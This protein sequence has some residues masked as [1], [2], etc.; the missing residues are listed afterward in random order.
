LTVLRKKLPA[1][2]LIKTDGNEIYRAMGIHIGGGFLLTA[3]HVIPSIA[4]LQ[5][6]TFF[7]LQSDGT[8]D[9]G[10]AGNT[11]T[12]GWFFQPKEGTAHGESTCTIDA[13]VIRLPRPPDHSITPHLGPSAPSGNDWRFLCLHFGLS[14]TEQHPQLCVAAVSDFQQ[15]DG[16]WAQLCKADVGPGGSGS[17]VLAIH[18]AETV[19]SVGMVLG[20]ATAS[21]ADNELIILS[22]NGM[23]VALQ[24]V[25]SYLGE[26][27]CSLQPG[28]Q[29]VPLSEAGESL[30]PFR[31]SQVFP[32]IR[33][34]E[35]AD[36]KALLEV[37]L[38]CFRTKY[39]QEEALPA[40]QR[41]SLF[42]GDNLFAD[43][44]QARQVCLHL[45]TVC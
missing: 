28:V 38:A 9:R 32:P 40:Y 27:S 25:Q 31:N 37:M 18:E 20:K 8:L 7:F 34:A 39:D 43:D 16:P 19:T 1:I 23:H 6:S 2:C 30:Q 13:A 4:H 36:D 17:F 41:T 15:A 5:K 26:A 12:G 44:L 45:L 35:S 14:L 33:K 42:D 29:A 3:S 11:A 21:S 24:S 22:L 10:I